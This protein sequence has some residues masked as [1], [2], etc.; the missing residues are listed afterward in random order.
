[1]ALQELEKPS[2]QKRSQIKP[3]QPSSVTQPA[4]WGLDIALAGI[5]EAGYPT[6]GLL[7][8][9]PGEPFLAAEAAPVPETF[10]FTS[11]LARPR[12]PLT[13]LPSIPPSANVLSRMARTKGAAKRKTKRVGSSGALIGELLFWRATWK[14]F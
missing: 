14:E 11:E 10:T 5:K 1:M 2:L 8:S 7:T 4:N 9:L 12:T 13:T 3:L 6:M